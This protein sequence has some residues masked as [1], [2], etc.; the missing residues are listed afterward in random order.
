MEMCPCGSGKGYIE[1]CEPLIQDDRKAAT[2]EELLRSR[3]TAYTKV[4]LEYLYATTHPSQRTHYDSEG[5]RKWAE[6][7]DWLSLEILDVNDGGAGDD[8]GQIEFLAHYA[9]KD[10][11]ESHHELALFEKANGIWYFVDGKPVIPKQ[12]KREVAKVGRNEPCPCGSG[13]KY[14]KCCG[15]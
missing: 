4:E 5:T 6:K 12:F 10:K 15:A 1:C 9:K 8:K 3:Y 13:K 2:A 11:K 14:K 7:S